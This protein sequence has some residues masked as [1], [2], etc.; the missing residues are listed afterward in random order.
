MLNRL[1]FERGQ[2]R[3]PSRAVAL[4][5]V[6]M[7]AA[8]LAGMPGLARADG[9]VDTTADSAA[10]NA[11]AA[12]APYSWTPWNPCPHCDLLAGVGATYSFWNFTDGIVVPITLEIDDSRWELGAFRFA[13]PQYLKESQLPSSYRS[14]NPQ[15]GFDA[16][17][18]WQ[19][20]HRSWGKLYI[21]FG[22][23]YKTEYDAL[24]PRFD[25]AYALAVRF[26]TPGHSI[27]EFSV[28]HWSDA[29][30]RMPNRGVNFFMLSLGL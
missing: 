6:L 28:R 12:T 17:R 27:L 8:S 5:C 11:P 26:N 30:F 29:W 4:L 7:L 16:L 1:P 10:A 13:T 14:A 22:G 9:T 25:F 19:L 3:M 24:D 21:G 18:R 15:W 23:S 2:G 20:L